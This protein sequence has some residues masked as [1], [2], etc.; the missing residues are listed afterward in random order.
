MQFCKDCGGVLNLFG[1]NENDLCS[2]CVQQQKRMAQLLAPA[3]VV[4]K[5][6]TPAGLLAET[7]LSLENGK[8]VLRSKEGWELW[9]AQPGVSTTL[10]TMLARARRIYE[11]RLRRQK[12]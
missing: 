8:I 9:S 4:Q 5:T 1:N 10:Q 7:V 12:N 3:A 6:E 2:A 11:I